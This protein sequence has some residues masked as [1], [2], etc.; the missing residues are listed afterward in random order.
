MFLEKLEKAKRNSYNL[1]SMDHQLRCQI[2]EDIASVL[3]ASKDYILKENQKDLSQAEIENISVSLKDRLKLDEKRLDS[4]IDSLRKIIEL[5]DPL[6][7]EKSWT[8]KNGMTITKVRVPIGLL[9]VFYEAR[10]NVTTDTIGLALK[11]GNSVILKGS[12]QTKYTNIAIEKVIQDVL[13]KYNLKDNILFFSDLNHEES[14]ELLKSSKIDLVIPRGGENLKNFVK[15]N[16]LAPV[17]GAGG[18]VCHVYVAETADLKSAANIIFNAKTQRPSVCNALECVLIHEKHLNQES[19]DLLFKKLIDFGVEISENSEDYG[20][21]FLDL[22]LCV[23]TVNS[24][25]SAIEH[26]NFYG[27]GH[28][29]SIITQDMDE[30]KIFCKKIDSACVY[31][32]A[33]TRFT[34]GEEFGFGAEIGIST[35]K[36]HARGP[37]GPAQLTSYKYLILGKGQVRD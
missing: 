36:L 3:S 16:S 29:D 20:K 28:S 4:M 11:T 32:N 19:F 1:A 31:V 35:Q 15:E 17:L 23:K 33:S 10:P 27:T 21:E 26:I 37:I 7:E 24:L 13:R 12:R 34:D 8:H 9:L 5:A 25:D 18:G 22:K 2:I 30:A 6:V 14:K